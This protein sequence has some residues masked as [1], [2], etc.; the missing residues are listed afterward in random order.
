MVGTGTDP[1]R[2]ILESGDE[3]IQVEKLI[4]CEH[5]ICEWETINNGRISGRQY[6]KLSTFI[7]VS[8]FYIVT[9]V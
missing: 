6:S 5:N 1:V 2:L 9:M 4:F 3:E 8:F 7:H